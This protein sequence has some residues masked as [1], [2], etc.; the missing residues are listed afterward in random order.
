MQELGVGSWDNEPQ[1]WG[2]W[3]IP[4][5]NIP[6]KDRNKIKSCCFKNKQCLRAER[7]VDEPHYLEDENKIFNCLHTL[8]ADWL[9]LKIQIADNFGSIYIP[10][11]QKVGFL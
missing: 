9:I 2:R 10:K 6:V 8:T 1:F 11:T 7:W 3:E 4:W 5:K